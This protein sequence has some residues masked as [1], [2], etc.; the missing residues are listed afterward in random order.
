MNVLVACHEP[1]ARHALLDGLRRAGF[2]A[3]AAP[4]D[5]E[6]TL[7]LVRRRRP[8]VV[9]LDNEFPGLNGVPGL[10]RMVAEIAGTPVVTVAARVAERNAVQCVLAGAMGYVGRQTSSPTLR[11]VVDALMR[12]EAAIPRSMTTAL[13]KLARSGAGMRPVR[14][15]LTAREW[16]VLDLM[17]LG[18]SNQQI[19]NDLVVSLETVQSHIKHILRKLGVHSRADA[20]ARADEL[21]H[22]RSPPAEG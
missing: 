1:G 12:G 19:A 20:I 14:S 10:R 8:D 16:E 5:G 13:I 2:D 18:A 15:A 4:P 7:D 6:K 3:I 9:F 11:R 17:T 22:H 21:R